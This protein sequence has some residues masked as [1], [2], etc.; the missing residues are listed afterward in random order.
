MIQF[1]LKNP[2]DHTRGPLGNP[3]DFCS[4]A[5][6]NY[7]S[8][9][10]FLHWLWMSLHQCMCLS[11]WIGCGQTPSIPSTQIQSI[12][13]KQLVITIPIVYKRHLPHIL[14]LWTLKTL[15]IWEASAQLY[16]GSSRLARTHASNHLSHGQ[17]CMKILSSP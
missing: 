17:A 16:G 2:R 4:R 3:L 1:P 6:G 12:L 11:S 14:V 7:M 15:G 8:L 5:G 13:P 10:F 9:G